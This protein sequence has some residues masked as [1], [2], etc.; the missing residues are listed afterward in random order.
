M[1]WKLAFLNIVV[2]K[3]AKIILFKQNHESNISRDGKSNI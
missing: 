1:L 3:I 2:E